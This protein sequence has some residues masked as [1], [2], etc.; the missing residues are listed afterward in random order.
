MDKAE[1]YKLLAMLTDQYPKLRDA[2]F[3]DRTA[4]QWL[5]SFADRSA[6]DVFSAIQ[7]H[8]TN[9]QR[10][11]FFPNVGEI[12]AYLP[13][14][15]ALVQANDNAALKLRERRRKINRLYHDQRL[16]PFSEARERGISSD[17]WERIMH[18][19]KCVLGYFKGA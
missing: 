3:T 11:R 12:A 18:D 9:P 2:E 1:V 19:A 4:Q 16:M 10:G 8:M 13:Q 14:R 15:L 5:I 6:Q 7:Q 17:E